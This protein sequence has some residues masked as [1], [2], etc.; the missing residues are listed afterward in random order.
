MFAI[1][2]GSENRQEKILKMLENDP[3]TSVILS[4][5]HFEWMIKRAILKLGIS[6]TKALGLRLE[7]IYH[8]KDAPGR[9]GYKTIWGDEVAK[10]RERAKL[11][12]VIGPLE[13]IQNKASKV[14]GRLV[15]GNGT[16]SQ[17]DAEEAVNLFLNASEKIRA[18]VLNNGEDIDARLA[19]RRKPRRRE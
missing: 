10:G 19:Q 12:I 13:R 15:H 8:I 7:G 5:V 16:V 14:R 1:S 9:I 3:A 18:F 11:G 2:F 17:T 6:P 4:A